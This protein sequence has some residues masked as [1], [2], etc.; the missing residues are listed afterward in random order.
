MKKNALIKKL[1]WVILEANEKGACIWFN[2]SWH[3]DWIEIHMAHSKN[4]YKKYIN[5]PHSDI[6]NRCIICIDNRYTEYDSE[7]I[8]DIID[9]ISNKY[10]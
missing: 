9:F 2:I 5:F 7:K 10:L 8:Q 1:V 3:V 4:N 6:W